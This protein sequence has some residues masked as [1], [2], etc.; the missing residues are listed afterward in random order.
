MKTAKPLAT[1]R[2]F[3]RNAG[4]TLVLPAL[5]SLCGSQAVASTNAPV[6]KRFVAIG[7]Y[8]GLHQKAIFPEKT[9]RDYETTTLLEP[10]ARHRENYTVFSGLDHRAGNGHARWGTFL[11]GT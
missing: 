2:Q 10:L 3:I 4:I 6:A 7:A 5:E 1:R 8:L 9:G 11:C